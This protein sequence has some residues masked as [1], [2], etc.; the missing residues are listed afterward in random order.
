M[1]AMQKM[2]IDAIGLKA[3]DL[4]QMKQFADDFAHT[5]KINAE[6]LQAINKKI[7]LILELTKPHAVGYIE[8]EFIAEKGVEN[9]N[10]SD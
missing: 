7:D 5:Q 2:I 9:D 10:D 1:L 8:D 4:H 6:I 3:D